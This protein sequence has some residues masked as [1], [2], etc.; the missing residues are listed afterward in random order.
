MP[1]A[2]CECRESTAARYRRH[3]HHQSARDHGRLGSPHRR[4]GRA[5][6]RLAMPPHRRVLRGTR[7]LAGAMA[8]AKKT[9]LVIDAYFSASKIRWILDHVPGARAKARDG[10]LLFG[11]IDTWLIW[12]LTNGAVARHRSLQ[13]L[14]HDADEP[15]APA[16]GTTNCSAIFDIPRAMLPQI[17][18]SSRRGW[19]GGGGASWAAEIP[20]CGHRGRSAGGAVRAGVLLSPGCPRTP[21]AP[22]ASP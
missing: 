8:I 11:N 6:H 14:A 4:A 1:R 13:R 20:I 19:H 12:K 2:A 21:T 17:V 9:G 16:I 15:R 22:D 3:R 5:R 10:E 7:R 18:P